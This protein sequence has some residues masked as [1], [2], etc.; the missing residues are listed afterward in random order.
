MD[1]VRTAEELMPER[2]RSNKVRRR[3]DD[4]EEKGEQQGGRESLA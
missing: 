2:G 4:K 3:G 1:G